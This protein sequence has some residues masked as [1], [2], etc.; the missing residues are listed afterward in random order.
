MSQNEKD[1]KPLNQVMGIIPLEQAYLREKMIKL[2]LWNFS[3]SI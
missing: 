2:S 1:H 3:V